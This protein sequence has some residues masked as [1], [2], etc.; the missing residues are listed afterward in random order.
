MS[1][2]YD[3]FDA[4]PYDQFDK[5]ADPKIGRPEELSFAEKW[6]APALERFSETVPGSALRAGNGNL[7]GSAIGGAMMG[8]ADPGV[9]AVQMAANAIGHG[10]AA[11]KRIQEVEGQYQD[12]RK[13][14]GRDG[15]DLARVA[16]NV[17]ITAPIGAGATT[18]LRGAAVGGASG[19]LD[20]I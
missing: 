4:N 14:A 6:L 8:A 5:K 17:A 18:I 19:L 10:D 7:R 12:A 2:P 1:N 11:N 3:Q 15:I 16:G 20:P 9:A 13:G